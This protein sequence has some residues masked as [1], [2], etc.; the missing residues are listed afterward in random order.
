[1]TVLLSPDGHRGHSISDIY[2]VYEDPGISITTYD[3]LMTVAAAQSLTKIASLAVEAFDTHEP[4]S[5]TCV[6]FLT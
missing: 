2:L 5:R 6:L 1:M 3:Q 4:D